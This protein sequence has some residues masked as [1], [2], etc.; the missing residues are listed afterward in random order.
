MI[1]EF[2]F[3]NYRSYRNEAT[4]GFLAKPI[5]EFEDTL[6]RTKGED[7]L[8]PVC[9]IYGP[10]GGGKSSVIM[11]I[12][13]L[14]QIVMQPLLQL[15]FMKKKNEELGDAPI[16]QLKDGLADIHITSS[17]YKWD[18][19]YADKPTKFN[20]LFQ[21]DDYKYRYELELK[22]E[23]IIVE[24][25][26]ME[27]DGCIEVIFERDEEGVFLCD[28]LESVDMENI[29]ESLPILSYIAMFKNIDIIDRVFKFF[30]QIKVLNY[31]KPNMDRKIF[32]KQIEKDKKR[33]CSVLQSMGIDICDIEVVYDDDGSIKEIYTTHLLSSGETT[34]LCLSEESGGTKKIISIIPILLKGIEQNCLF[35]ID[36]LD[37]KL[38]P[39]LLRRIIELFT[40]KR[41]N[42]GTA[43]LLFTSHDLTTMSKDVF[44]RD[45]IW[46]SA[47]NAYEES[48]LY[49]LVDFR[50]EG[51]NKPRNDENYSKQYLEGR[52]GAD[53]Y[54]KK[55]VNW[56]VPE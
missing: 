33:V 2:S 40:D 12:E 11:A 50:K 7:A 26:Y 41:I 23:D 28:K 20:I 17:Y 8:L 9:A 27:K 55:L 24:N 54:F 6:I 37:A 34:K 49:S 22:K 25:L 14:R 5:S 52:Y 29:N 4:I 21:I 36:E 45:E 13:E 44:R 19:E 30:M 15:A 1:Y 53:P 16:E 51:G 10:N 39:L 47:I 18:K 43:Q 42:K 3:E 46:F 38:H 48:V 32:V 56:E 35:L 31:D